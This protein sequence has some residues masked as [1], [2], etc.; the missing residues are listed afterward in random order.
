M[1]SVIE[2]V[3]SSR[4]QLSLRENIEAIVL[5]MMA[6]HQVAPELHRV[7]E[8]EFPYFD[9]PWGQNPE[10]NNIFRRVRVLLE[11]HRHEIMPCNLD[12][13]THTTLQILV[14]LVHAAVIEPCAQFTAREVEGAIV[15]SVLGYL[16]Y[17]PSS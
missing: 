12:L 9:A 8:K 10:H 11:A 6:A 16:V 4:H 3:L 7:L 17:A 2:E 5:A 15:D 14:T 1:N 13:A